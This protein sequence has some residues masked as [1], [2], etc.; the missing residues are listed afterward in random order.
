M[1][2]LA[3][4]ADNGGMDTQI[5]EDIQQLS[6][7]LETEESAKVESQALS[8][9]VIID[10]GTTGK[11]GYG[12]KHIIEGR[13]TEGKSPQEISCLL[14]AVLDVVRNGTITRDIKFKRNPQHLG[15][16]EL[17]KDGIIAVISKQREQGDTEKWLLTGYDDKKREKEATD[18]IHAI[19]AK[20][21]YTPEFSGYQKLVG[22][23]ATSLNVSIPHPPEM[24]SGL[25]VKS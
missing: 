2:F 13:L 6:A 20:Y 7:V 14:I 23:V 11:S 12:L 22:A 24:S 18:T 1:L 10:A 8:G 15:R 21:G 4:A 9:D 19:Y 25:S 16:A 5:E 17:E 3:G